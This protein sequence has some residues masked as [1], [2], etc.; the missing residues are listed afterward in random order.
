MQYVRKQ[1]KVDAIQLI[2]RT[3]LDMGEG[4]EIVGEAGD[5]LI[6][7]ESGEHII[8]T[9]EEFKM[10]YE[11]IS[12]ITKPKQ[13]RKSIAPDDLFKLYEE[14][15]PK[16]HD[17]SNVSTVSPQPTGYYQQSVQPQQPQQ[18][19]PPQQ[20]IKKKKSGLSA[21]FGASKKKRSKSQ[22][23]DSFKSNNIQII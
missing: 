14:S 9:D 19:A 17:K 2:T 8:L 13:E 1:E 6:K 22:E 11:P 4:E 23:T 18:P 20:Q 12:N 3:V 7:T 16:I 15:P 5:W 21:L 10:K